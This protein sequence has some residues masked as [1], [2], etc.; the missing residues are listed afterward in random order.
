M[1][2]KDASCFP[3]IIHYL[4]SVIKRPKLLRAKKGGIFGLYCICMSDFKKEKERK[5]NHLRYLRTVKMVD[6]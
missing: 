4:P 5:K 6:R 1:E 3:D 2:N